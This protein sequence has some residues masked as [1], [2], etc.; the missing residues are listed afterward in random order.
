MNVCDEELALAAAGGD[1]EAFGALLSRVYDR[2]FGLAFKLT[3]NRAEAEDLVQDICAALPGKLTRFRGDAK[4]TTWLYRIVVNAARDRH[5]RRSTHAKAASGWGDWEVSRRA[6]EAEAAE[7][8]DWLRLAMDALTPPELRETLVL[9]L[10]GLNHAQVAE[11]LDVSEGTISWRISE[12]KKKL[13]A[14]KERDA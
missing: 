10:E 7:R 14:M 8:A 2:M 13:R 6:A 4:V 11:I 9:V 3:G 1:R 5:R 12:A